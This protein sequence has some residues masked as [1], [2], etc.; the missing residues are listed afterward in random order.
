[1]R[2]AGPLPGMSEVRNTE[3]FWLLNWDKREHLK[4]ATVH[5]ERVVVYLKE[6]EC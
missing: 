2:V 1:M 5:G 4:D 6:R 3:K